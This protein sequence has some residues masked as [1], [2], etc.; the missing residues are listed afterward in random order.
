[1]CS[2]LRQSRGSARCLLDG[3]FLS[4]TATALPTTSDHASRE[5]P[6]IDLRDVS[7][8]YLGPHERVL[9]FKEYVITWLRGGMAT[10]ELNALSHVNLTVRR[11]E[12]VGVIGRNGA[13]KSTLLKI[14]A[15]VLRPTSG[16]AKVHGVV[17]P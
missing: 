11:G 10:E 8:R 12:S 3:S 1:M 6:I 15:R 7:V 13:G 5:G 16:T 17:A 2:S 4:A 9:T 14:I